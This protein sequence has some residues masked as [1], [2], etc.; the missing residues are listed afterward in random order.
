MAT[1][2]PVTSD[3]LC[4]KTEAQLAIMETDLNPDSNRDFTFNAVRA[5][6]DSQ[7]DTLTVD[8][9]MAKPGSNAARHM[10]LKFLT[11]DTTV[12]DATAVPDF[13]C[14]DE[15]DTPLDYNTVPI[16]IDDAI[17]DTFTIDANLYDA[18]C[19]D[20]MR[21]LQEKI[22]RSVR[23][24]L[25]QY[26]KK[27]VT[28][29][30]TNVGAYADGT[31]ATKDL[32][33][34]TSGQA[35]PQPMGWH[36]LINEYSKQSPVSGETPYVISG[37]EKLQAYQ[38]ASSVFSGNVDGYDPNK[39]T[40]NGANIYF[41]RA[42]QPVLEGI[43]AL[44]TSGVLAFMPGS[45]TIAEFFKFENP[46]YAVNPNG[47]SVY[48]P[49]QSSGTITRQKVDVG[50]PTLGIP[51]VVDMQIEYR[52]C[53]NKVVYKWRKDFD[54]CHL[55]QTAFASTFN[56]TTLWNIDCGDVDCSVLG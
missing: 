37:A 31:T 45:V 33:L 5:I 19:E 15:T 14:T 54:L 56:Y 23:K 3:I 52:E 1:G 17:G 26:Q 18:T 36:S 55:P 21:E 35:K 7:R 51:F 9:G 2:A 24:G 6:Q 49:V 8:P 12:G 47:R 13:T 34:F 39:A 50:T 38:Y 43:D 29:M 30:H 25:A 40:S 48:A 53:D 27:L 28:K 11:P 46:I 41:D 16:T 32:L 4:Q 20:P 44:L 22:K 42:V 10:Y